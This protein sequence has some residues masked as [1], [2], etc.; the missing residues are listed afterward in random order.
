MPNKFKFNIKY[1]KFWKKKLP[2]S[3]HIIANLKGEYTY[4]KKLQQI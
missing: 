3:S 2:V 1:I 4:L